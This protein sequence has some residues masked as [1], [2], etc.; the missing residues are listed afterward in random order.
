MDAYRNLLEQIRDHL[1]RYGVRRWPP[2]LDEWIQELDSL[3]P[4]GLKS[5]LHRTLKS[6]GGMGSIGDIVICPEAGHDIPTERPLIKAVND[7][8]VALT[9]ELYAEAKRRLSQ[10]EGG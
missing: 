9:D 4:E 2:R 7:R 8:L 10:L 3:G 1:S 6:L 5:H